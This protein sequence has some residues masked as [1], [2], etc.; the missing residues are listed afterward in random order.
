MPESGFSFFLWMTM[1]FTILYLFV[2]SALTT[3]PKEQPV[4]VTTSGDLKRRNRKRAL[5]VAAELRRTKI[6]D[7]PEPSDTTD[8]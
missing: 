3:Q 8:I 1:G 5:L 7:Q 4:V 2:L 6:D